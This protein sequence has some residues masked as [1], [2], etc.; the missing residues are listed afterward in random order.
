MVLPNISKQQSHCS[1]VCHGL[2]HWCA[3]CMRSLQVC[4]S[5]P[6]D[7][8]SCMRHAAQACHHAAPSAW[9]LPQK[10]GQGKTGR[11]RQEGKDRKGKTIQDGKERALLPCKQYHTLRLHQTMVLPLPPFVGIASCLLS[12]ARFF[13]LP[14]TMTWC[15]WGFRL[16]REDMAAVIF[17]SPPQGYQKTGTYG[18]KSM[19]VLSGY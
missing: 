15:T 13:L 16:R 1:S 19:N 11:G 17:C 12:T 18:C 8:Y 9:W 2:W 5:E 7:P 3:A 10:M 4:A 6:G 14:L